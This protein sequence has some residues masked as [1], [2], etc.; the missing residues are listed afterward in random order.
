ME[1][2]I[3]KNFLNEDNIVKLCEESILFEMKEVHE[4]CKENIIKSLGKIKNL[5]KEMTRLNYDTFKD[6]ISSDKI[7]A[8]N[9]KEICDIV[10]EYIKFRRE[11]PEEIKENINNNT[12]NINNLNIE[13]KKENEEKKEK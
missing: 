7:D 4:Q 2:I 13:V 12:K 5:T 10:I 9:E 3:I 1:K 11:I 8:E 6:I